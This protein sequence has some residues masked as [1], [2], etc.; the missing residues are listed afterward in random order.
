MRDFMKKII[1]IILALVLVA[2]SAFALVAC[3]DDGET[4]GQKGLLMKKYT[5]EE[6]YTVYGYV[7]EGEGITSLDIGAVAGEKTVGRIAE[8]AFS[9]NDTLVEVVV[10]D[11]VTEISSGAFKKMKKLEKITLPFVGKTAIAD[12][13]IYETDQAENK[14]VDAERTFGF[15]FGSEEYSYGEAITANYG[16]STATYYIPASLTEVTIKPAGEY[17]IPMYAFAGTVLIEKVN[18]V[19]NFTVIGENAFKGCRDL[20]VINVPSTVKTIYSYA[21]AECEGLKEGLTFDAGSTLEV[22]KDYAF[23]NSGIKQIMLPASV[24]VMGSFVFAESSVE[25][26]VLSASLENVGAYAF[27]G[28]SN[29]SEVDVSAVVGTPKLGASAFEN[30]AKLEVSGSLDNIWSEKGANYKKGTK[31]I[32]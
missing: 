13:Y 30:C 16:V 15:I 27:F 5:G 4:N 31:E 1:N 22:I 26:I 28:C 19:G 24:K 18:L 10:P 29:L 20:S 32:A 11:T 17:K 21:F 14:S 6:F 9:G 23:A 7:D 8:G 12:A 25:K 2:V 3:G